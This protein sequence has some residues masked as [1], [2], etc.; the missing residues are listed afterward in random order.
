MNSTTARISPVDLIPR[1]QGG[2]L[3][4]SKMVDFA[5]HA[6]PSARLKA[7]I[8]DRAQNLDVH[9]SANHTDYPPLRWCPIGLS[10]ETKL[11]G[12]DWDQA[13]T[14]V[15]IWTAAHFSKLEAL[16]AH[17][18]EIAERCGDETRRSVDKTM[19]FLP[20]I[21]TQGHDWHFLAATR[22]PGSLTVCFT[23]SSPL[24]ILLVADQRQIIHEKISFGSTSTVL[25]V[26]Q[27]VATLQL[28]ARWVRDSFTPWYEAACFGLPPMRLHDT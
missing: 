24:L 21:I 7:A 10:I 28:L 18:D 1:G 14:Q 8:H 6:E 2:K 16:I 3:S 12:R 23:P 25:G 4:R 15:A 5:V 11:T 13:R 27:V 20:I 22:M 19:P 26:Y 9:M 17:A